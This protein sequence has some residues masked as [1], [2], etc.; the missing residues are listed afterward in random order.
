MFLARKGYNSCSNA[1]MAFALAQKQFQSKFSLNTQALRFYSNALRKQN[2]YQ[3]RNMS[4]MMGKR[5]FS[6][7]TDSSGN[8][9][10][11]GAESAAAAEVPMSS[12]D[13][14]KNS[15]KEF[16]KQVEEDLIIDEI[17]KVEEWTTKV[18]EVTDVPIILDFYAEW[19]APCKKLTPQLEKVTQEHEGKF[20]LI[21]INI[22]NLPNI[23]TALQV[24]SIPTL[25]LIY[26]GNVMDQVT[27]VDEAKLD[28]L[29]KTALLVEEAQ[30]S[31]SIM[32]SALNSCQ[33]FIE[34]GKYAEAE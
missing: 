7:I 2:S 23:A 26:R 10:S 19:C 16:L 5:Q 4:S 30:H 31:E 28:E 24:K 18:M 8:T 29:V 6:I 15:A 9:I 14:A 25:F 3:I 27:G 1:T 20:K 34:Q 11:G 22:D 12:E 21:K 17:T 13:A 33:E 32:D